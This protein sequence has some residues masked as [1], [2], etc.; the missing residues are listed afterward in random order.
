MRPNRDFFAKT[1]QKCAKI[2]GEFLLRT[3]YMYHTL[4][5]ICNII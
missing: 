2:G 4:L 1:D 3:Y 5:Y